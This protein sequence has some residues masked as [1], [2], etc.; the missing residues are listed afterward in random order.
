MSTAPQIDP[1]QTGTSRS[2]PGSTQTHLS[3][4]TGTR[5]GMTLVPKGLRQDQTPATPEQIASDVRQVGGLRFDQVLLITTLMIVVVIVAL[6]GAVFTYTA[7]A[8]FEESDRQYTVTLQEQAR[9]MGERLAT[10]LAQSAQLPMRDNDYGYFKAQA[11]EVVKQNSNVARI[12]FFA[13]DRSVLAD[14]DGDLTRATDRRFERGFTTAYYKGTSVFEYSEPVEYGSSAGPGLVVLNYSLDRLQGLLTE[15][16]QKQ[17]QTLD[18][19]AV[20]TGLLGVLFLVCAGVLAAVV[21]RRITRPLGSLTDGVM[22][23]AQGDFDARVE[24]GTGSREVKTL[25][26]VFNHMADRIALLMND[27]RQK[28]FLEREMQVAKTVQETLLPNRDVFPVGPIKIAGTSFAAEACGGD[29]WFRSALGSSRVVIGVGDV[30]GHGLSTALVATSATSGFASAIK[31]HEPSQIH[32]RLLANALNQTLFHLARGEFQMSTSLAVVD[33]A[34]GMMEF[35]SGGHP[36]AQ[37]FNREDGKV[38]G[39]TIRGA[40]LGLSEHSDYAT[41][42]YQLRPGDVVVW[43]SDGLTEAVNAEG[44]QYSLKRLQNALRQY[45]YL[46]PTQLRDAIVTEV[47]EFMAGTAQADDVTIVVAEYQ[48]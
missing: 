44:K 3:H 48:P 22:H 29:W 20:R 47:Q 23:L 33:L 42:Q 15:M 17:A 43:Y 21:S 28:A 34:S 41:A 12:R 13:A 38:T 10:T 37:V 6:L 7:R 8:A 5:T 30:T 4:G 25:G 11:A 35:A 45:G 2:A 31:L 36:P 19:S 32:C 16:A 18:A 14:S 1:H 40:L 9:E 39:L 46:P 24:A 26:I 27:V